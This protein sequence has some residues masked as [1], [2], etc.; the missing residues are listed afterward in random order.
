[1]QQPTGAFFSVFIVRWG[2]RAAGSPLELSLVCLLTP[3]R[4]KSF[5]SI[6]EAF[7]SLL[8]VR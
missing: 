2:R 3:R 4:E 7:F 6:F 5:G 1:M 8:I